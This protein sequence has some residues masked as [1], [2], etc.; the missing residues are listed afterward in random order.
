VSF[1]STAI[2]VAVCLAVLSG[3]GAPSGSTEP[4]PSER[5]PG[6]ATTNTFLFGAN[7]F[8]MPAENITPEHEAL[9]YAGNSFFNQAW[10][11]APA[12]TEARDGLGPLFNARSCAGCHFKD[13]R[14]RPSLASQDPALGLL[15]RLSVPGRG[16]HGEPLPEPAYGGQFQPFAIDHVPAEGTQSIAY[17][18]EEGEYADGETYS[19]SRPEY[20]FGDL[21]YGP[22]SEDVLVSPRVAPATIGMGLLEAIPDSRLEE[23]ADPNDDDRDGVSGKINLVWDAIEQRQRL[24]RFGWKAEQP[25]VRQQSAGAFLGDMGI[26]TDV[27]GTAD[28]TPAEAECAA[29]LDGGAPEAPRDV[30]DRVE[31]YMHLIAVPAR[32]DANDLDVLSGRAIFSDIGCAGCHVPRHVTGD[33]EGLPEVSGQTI[34]P[35]TDLLLHDLGPA[36]SDERPSFDAEGAEW[37]TPP[38]WGLHYYEAVNGHDRLLHDGRARGVAEAILWHGGE[39]EA[40]RDRFRA[41]TAKERAELVDFVESL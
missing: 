24:G 27:F 34:Y 28:C 9:F 30:L 37:R 19:L 26:T 5:L 38:L 32:N 40:A 15:L 3:C 7:A 22:L 8:T 29:A 20:A 6:G 41:L 13:G 25:S 14:G 2:L 10:V 18:E 11:Q 12:S 17:T 33:V 4:D 21:G 23:M 39:A 1:P 35:Y 31:L 16:E 36:L